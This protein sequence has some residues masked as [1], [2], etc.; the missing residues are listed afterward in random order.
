[1]LGELC[2]EENLPCVVVD[3]KLSGACRKLSKLSG[4]RRKVLIYAGK[5]R[6]SPETFLSETI[7]KVKTRLTGVVVPAWSMK[8]ISFMYINICEKQ[9]HESYLGLLPG[10][11]DLSNF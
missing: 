7:K 11:P 1:M 2:F 5:L 3:R 9:T 4:A 10:L 8:I 6:F